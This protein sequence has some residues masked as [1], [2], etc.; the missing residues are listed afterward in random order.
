MPPGRSHKGAAAHSTQI[1]VAT[2]HRP[3]AARSG[4]CHREHLGICRPLRFVVV[5]H[6]D[7]R[8]FFVTHGRN[9]TASAGRPPV[10]R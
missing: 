2:P 9:L 8:L 10:D 4:F 6:C 1:V 7:P 5:G 3:P